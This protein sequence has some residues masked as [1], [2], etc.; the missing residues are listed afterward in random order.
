MP[1]SMR[2][3]HANGNW[4][5]PDLNLCRLYYVLCTRWYYNYDKTSWN[6]NKIKIKEKILKIL[7][8]NIIKLS[9]SQNFT[10]NLDLNFVNFNKLKVIVII[11]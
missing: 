9:L 6:E 3:D 4:D 10:N 11:T 8:N 5:R 7:I 1:I 2:I